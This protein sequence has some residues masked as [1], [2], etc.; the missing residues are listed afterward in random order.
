MLND[1][2]LLHDSYSVFIVIVTIFLIFLII[3]IVVHTYMYMYIVYD[4]LPW[5]MTVLQ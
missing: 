1:S 5:I 2:V 4:S 3:I